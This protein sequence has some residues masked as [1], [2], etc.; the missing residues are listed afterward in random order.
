MPADLHTASMPRPKH[1]TT[2]LGQRV[3]RR[4]GVTRRARHLTQEKLAEKVG[5]SVETISRYE[6]GRLGISLEALAKIAAALD[7]P[8]ETLVRERPAGITSEEAEMLELW[9]GIDAEGRRRM[10]LLLQWACEGAPRS[11]G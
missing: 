2:S 6:S 1:S 5:L 10:Q 11:V 3:A 9:R 7:V 4:I 8:V